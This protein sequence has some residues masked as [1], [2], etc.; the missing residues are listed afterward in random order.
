M[1][2]PKRQLVI[3]SNTSPPRSPLRLASFDLNK[4]ETVQLGAVVIVMA[5]SLMLLSNL[6]VAEVQNSTSLWVGMVGSISFAF[7]F[8]IETTHL[9]RKLD[10]VAKRSD[11]VQHQR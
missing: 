9:L 7:V 4:K 6:G 8:I 3:C 11:V 5:C 2:G 1:T 10:K